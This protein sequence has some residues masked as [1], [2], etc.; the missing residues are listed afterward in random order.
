MGVAVADGAGGREPGGAVRAGVVVDVAA[1][2]NHDPRGVGVGKAIKFQ[3]GSII[4]QLSFALP[5]AVEHFHYKQSNFKS[6][7]DYCFSSSKSSIIIWSLVCS[8][9]S[10]NSLICCTIG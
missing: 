7:R 1:V 10:P 4:T 2:S 6:N 9:S 8:M 5:S 3:A